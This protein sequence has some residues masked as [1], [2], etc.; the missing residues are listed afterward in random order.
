M[1]QADM[2]FCASVWAMLAEDLYHIAE[3]FVESCN[4]KCG[5]QYFA[6]FQQNIGLFAI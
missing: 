4:L 1:S 5:N 6:G 3:G 2:E